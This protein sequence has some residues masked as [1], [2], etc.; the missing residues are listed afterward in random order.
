MGFEV[1]VERGESVS[2]LR[3]LIVNKDPDYFKG[4][5]ARSFN[6]WKLEIPITG[7]KTPQNPDL[8]NAIELGIAD[9]IADHFDG[10]LKQKHMHVVVKLPPPAG[11]WD[12]DFVF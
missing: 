2:G 7:D 4:T 5:S 11:K 1:K 10:P 9:E 8:S 12:S 3:K 6:L